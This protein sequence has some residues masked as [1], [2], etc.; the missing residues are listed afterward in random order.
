[1]HA[2]EVLYAA[3]LTNPR[4]TA[5]AEEKRTRVREALSEALVLQCARCRE[6]A[7]ADG[8]LPVPA[9]DV[10]DCESCGGSVNRSAVHR[11]AKACRERGIRRV[12]V[13]GGAPGVHR[14]L[15]SLWPTDLALRIIPGTN[16]TTR[17]EAS[18]NLAWAD[19]VLVWGST[20][21]DHR[22]SELYTRPGERKVV[23]VPRRGVA[24]LA[25]TLARHV[26]SR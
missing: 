13:V 3:G 12:V 8:R 21:L 2:L 24:A 7:P 25:E 5:I 4:K 15:E 10:A 11:A 20:E 18:A 16:R 1:L 17:R 14:A 23:L 6:T 22:V 19:V 26:G 9:A